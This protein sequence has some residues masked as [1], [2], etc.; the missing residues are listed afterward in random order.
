M[1]C[2]QR[3]LIEDVKDEQRLRK[4][5]KLVDDAMDRY[6]KRVGFAEKLES[7]MLGSSGKRSQLQS[8][9]GGALGNVGVRMRSMP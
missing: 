6:K 2:I 3:M 1:G 5:K 7:D 4:V 8:H 9:E